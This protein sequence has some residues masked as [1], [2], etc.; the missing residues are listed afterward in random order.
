[1]ESMGLDCFDPKL[2]W[3]LSPLLWRMENSARGGR[4]QTG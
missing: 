4:I 3:F 2:L 1:M